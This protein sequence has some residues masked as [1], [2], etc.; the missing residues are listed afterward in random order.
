MKCT[1]AKREVLFANGRCQML[2]IALVV[3]FVLSLKPVE[4][5]GACNNYCSK[6]T[7]KKNYQCTEKKLNRYTS[8]TS[9]GFLWLGRC[10]RRR[11]WYY[12]AYKCCITT[13]SV[14]GG[15]SSWGSW[16]LTTGAC[17]S[18][19]GQGSQ[20]YTRTRSCTNPSPKNG[21][22]KCNGKSTE[23]KSSSCF[24]SE[25]TVDGGWSSWGSWSLTRTCSSTCGRG[26]KT[27]TGTRSCTNPSPKNGGKNCDGPSTQNKNDTCF[28]SHCPVNGGW[29]G[30]GS[31]SLTTTCSSTCGQGSKTYTR[32]RRCTNPSPKYGGTGCNGESTDVN[33]SSCFVSEC[34]V[35]GGWNSWGSWSLTTTCSSTCGRGSKTYTRTR[36]CTNPSPKNGGKNCNGPST[37]NKNDTCFSSHCPVNGGWGGWGKWTMST[38]CSS[39]CGRGFRTYA[40]TRRC[41]NPSPK[42]EGKDCSGLST[43]YYNASCLNTCSERSGWGSWGSWSLSTTCSSTCGQ[44]SQTYTRTRRC[45]NPSPEKGG[46]DC[47]GQSAEYKNNSCFITQCP[48]NYAWDMWGSWFLSRTCTSTC[49]QGYR[50]YTRSRRCTNQSTENEEIDCDGQ[51]TEYRNDT[52]FLT[53]CPANEGWN[54]WDSWTLYTACTSECGQGSQMYKRTRRCMNP[55]NGEM[56]CNGLSTDYKNDSCFITQCQVI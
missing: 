14:D 3:I 52:C 12:Q 19:C 51:S 55:E 54:S 31:W 17:S 7:G 37:Q 40:R 46:K 34:S 56:D 2:N 53:H 45:T 11:S 38:T 43:Q 18:T 35:D 4:I 6:Q 26:S 36:R 42:N 21:G 49:G 22:N 16:S 23:V 48:V 20:T 47:I 13:C 8:Y 25:C 50:T 15:W 24:M 30:W 44:G 39:T 1:S 28:S 10:S 41:T 27:Y 29:G 33:T 5:T 32:T 9:C